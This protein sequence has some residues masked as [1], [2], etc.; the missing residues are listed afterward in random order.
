MK[1]HETGFQSHQCLNYPRVFK[2]AKDH[3]ELV[4]IYNPKPARGSPMQHSD[5]VNVLTAAGAIPLHL[6]LPFHL[7]TAALLEILLNERHGDFVVETFPGAKGGQ[8]T[9]IKMGASHRILATA[10]E[11]IKSRQWSEQALND[12]LRQHRCPNG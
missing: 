1:N 2:N 3:F 12:F 4:L 6:P 7:V 9:L 11:L 5:V 8:T 10:K